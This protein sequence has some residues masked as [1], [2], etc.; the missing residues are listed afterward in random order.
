VIIPILTVASI[1]FG[2]AIF[3]TLAIMKHEN[4][5]FSSKLLGAVISHLWEIESEGSGVLSIIFALVG[6]GY[7]LYAARKPK[8]KAAFQPL[9]TPN[10]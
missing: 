2:D 5:P 8:F 3:Y 9:G 7:A 4:A 1:L 10:A 6:A